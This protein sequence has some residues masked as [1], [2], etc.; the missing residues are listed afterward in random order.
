MGHLA[1]T[2]DLSEAGMRRAVVFGSVM[3]SF[4]VESFS[5]DRMRAL[6]SGEIDARYRA[7]SELAHFERL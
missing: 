1:A 4:N 3:A 5:Y 2:G 7:F 6:T